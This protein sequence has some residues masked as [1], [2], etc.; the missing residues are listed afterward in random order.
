MTIRTNTEAPITVVRTNLSTDHCKGSYTYHT[1]RTMKF[2]SHNK[3]LE[4][5]KQKVKIPGN[6]NIL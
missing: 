4:K 3:M 1:D 6:C 2:V 5:S